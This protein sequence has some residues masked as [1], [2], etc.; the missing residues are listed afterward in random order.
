MVAS[1]PWCLTMFL[2]IMPTDSEI[3]PWMASI[4]P[5]WMLVISLP[6]DS[7]IVPW[8]ATIFLTECWRPPCRI[9][10][11]FVPWMAANFHIK[12]W[13][14]YT[15]IDIES[16]PWMAMDFILLSVFLYL[17]WMCFCFLPQLTEFAK[18]T[19]EFVVKTIDWV[20]VKCPRFSI[21]GIPRFSGVLGTTF[22][23]FVNDRKYNNPV[24]CVHAW[25]FFYAFF[26]WRCSSLAFT[27]SKNLPGVM[28]ANFPWYLAIGL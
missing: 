28:T 6:I 7:E 22:Y 23:L 2:V 9:D 5:H 26:T 18:N 1:S 11:E 12:R 16:V 14:L 10:S 27:A 20:V 3:V 25:N 17:I 15:F 24:W 4:F 8:M 21:K 19:H 13:F